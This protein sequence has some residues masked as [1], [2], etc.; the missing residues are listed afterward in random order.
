MKTKADTENKNGNRYSERLDKALE[1][2]SNAV[3]DNKNIGVMK[4]KTLHSVMKYFYE[5]DSSFHEVKSGR[6]VA[7]ILRDDT[8]IEIQTCSFRP[9]AKKVNEIL[10][11]GYKLILVRPIDGVKYLSW[12]SEDGS[13][14]EPR[15]SPK[16]ETVFSVLPELYYLGDTVF[17]EDF[18]LRIVS[19]EM[20]EYRI[21]DGWSADG[22]K[23][24]HRHNKIPKE[25]LYSVDISKKLDY[26]MLLPDELPEI[27][28][29]KEF[30]SLT[31]L[32]KLRLSMAL[33]FLKNISLIE[34]CG[35]KGNAYLY[36]RCPDNVL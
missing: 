19:C 10:E 35:K 8:V 31:H 9:I 13:V 28:T 17:H 3:K 7:D 5:P 2:A 26:N 15:K 1:N 33:S 6:F 22:K 36:R 25:I 32:R 18:T 23:G 11:S 24:S 29:A 12:I 4:E 21:A 30:A 20:H 27:F 16:K 14:S 34:Q